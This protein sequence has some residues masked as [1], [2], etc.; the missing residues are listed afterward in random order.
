MKKYIHLIIILIS[1]AT[2]LSGLLL[3]FFPSLVLNIIGA[4]VNETSSYF[5][6]IVG[7]FMS[8]FG[9]LMLHAVY[10]VQ[11]QKR[12]EFL[13]IILIAGL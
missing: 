6:A 10:S 2:I 7:M 9:G 4:T 13:T 1:I 11:P 12:M 3:M 8:L 5:F